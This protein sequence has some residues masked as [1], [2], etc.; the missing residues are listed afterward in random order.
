MEDPAFLLGC[1]LDQCETQEDFRKVQN[2]RERNTIRSMSC[3]DV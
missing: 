1:V 3:V 2:A